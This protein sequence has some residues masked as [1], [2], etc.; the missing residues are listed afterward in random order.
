MQQ[1]TGLLSLTT[2]TSLHAGT[3]SSG[4]VI[5]LPIQ[6]EGHNGWP[7]VFGSAV[8]GAL[9]ARAEQLMPD[10]TADLQAAFGPD[11]GH[12]SD[13][14]GALSVGDARL[15]LMPVRS[16]TGTFRWVTCPA[17]LQRLRDDCQRL[18]LQQDE[19]DIPSLNDEATALLPTDGVEALYLEEYRFQTQTLALDTLI[20]ALARLLGRDQGK[21]LLSQ[22]LAIVHDDMFSHLVR[23]ATPVN[24]RVA[25]DEKKTVRRGALWY[26]ET[27]PPETLLYAPL[28]AL[29]SRRQD[30]PM[31][32]SAVFQVI[33]DKIFGKHP[34]LQL[35]GNETVGMGWCSVKIL[36]G[37]NA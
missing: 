19:W 31:D 13:H 6:R 7:C 34:W 10:T 36:K 35:G 21:D 23:T 16:L 4:D 5:D 15:L 17:A 28:M 29:P 1:V 26:E 37:A 30:H 33:T 3:G 2:D 18:N 14:A 32:A 22:R 12:A 27:L 24:A 9:R 25:L 20:D 11:T 8:K